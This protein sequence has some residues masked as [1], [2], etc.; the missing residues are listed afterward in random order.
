MVDGT[1]WLDTLARAFDL[2]DDTGP[3]PVAPGQTLAQAGRLTEQ[4]VATALAYP[5]SVLLQV[6][7]TIASAEEGD[8]ADPDAVVEQIRLVLN[9]TTRPTFADKADDLGLA[10]IRGS[11][12][13]GIAVST[14]VD[15]VGVFRVVGQVIADALAFRFP[16]LTDYRIALGRNPDRY[17]S[18]T[19]TY[20][21]TL[22]ADPAALFSCTSGDDPVLELRFDSFTVS[23]SAGVSF[24]LAQRDGAVMAVQTMTVGHLGGLAFHDVRLS[25]CPDGSR[26]QVGTV[27]L[28]VM[29]ESAAELAVFHDPRWTP[30]D[31]EAAWED[32]LRVAVNDTGDL[33]DLG[34][35]ARRYLFG[36]RLQGQHRL[37]GTVRYA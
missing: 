2:R 24:V 21:A 9:D 3:I 33:A 23:P 8:G 12:G 7:R 36:R 32:A 22:P 17:L 29:P 28:A 15:V 13:G 19:G 31:I 16:P 35:R 11:R 37:S 5:A 20:A 26:V 6:M 25:L 14:L 1:L 18:L 4:H 27:D 34:G 10:L 30:E